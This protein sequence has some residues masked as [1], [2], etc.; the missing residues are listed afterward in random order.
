MFT[1][2]S[3]V[4]LM[5]LLI[6]HDCLLLCLKAINTNGVFGLI[7]K[8]Q[9]QGSVAKELYPDFNFNP[10]RITLNYSSTNWP[11]IIIA[12]TF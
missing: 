4:K 7:K 8:N 6:W 11:K 10:I 5:S 2:L 3:K 1:H 9:Y 12:I